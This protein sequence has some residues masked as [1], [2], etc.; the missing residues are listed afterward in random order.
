MPERPKP[1]APPNPNLKIYD[2]RGQETRELGQSTDPRMRPRRQLT[3]LQRM[4]QAYPVRTVIADAALNPQN[5]DRQLDYLRKRQKAGLVVPTEAEQHAARQ[6]VAPHLDKM[7][8][9]GFLREYKR[10]GAPPVSSSQGRSLAYR[11]FENQRAARGFD[12]ARLRVEGQSAAK[13]YLL[14]KGMQRAASKGKLRPI[15]IV[16]RF[17]GK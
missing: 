9:R 8:I 16:L 10:Q 13:S 1:L 14:K 5:L 2:P 12:A 4:R 6:K 3:S 11:I 17:L 15:G 7:K